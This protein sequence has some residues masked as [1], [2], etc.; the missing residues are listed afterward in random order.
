MNI[1]MLWFDNDPK[2]SLQEKILKAV[3][4]YRRK[5]DRHPEVCLISQ[6]SAN[7][8][9][10]LQSVKF[11]NQEIAVRVWRGTLSHHFWVGVE[12]VMVESTK[13]Q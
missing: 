13:P 2:A 12:D 8:N 11:E 6:A 1:F 4:Y 10:G 9:P 5:Y 7:E 3:E